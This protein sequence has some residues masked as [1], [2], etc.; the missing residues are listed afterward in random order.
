MNNEQLT[1]GNDLS[2][3]IAKLKSELNLWERSRKL[4]KIMSD[5][6]G[7]NTYMEIDVS[8]INFE[9]LKTLTIDAI[10]KD[11]DLLEQQFN[12]L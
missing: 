9:V 10:K 11:L 7:Y 12:K 5:V 1:A 8:R 3:K 4:N 6:E 2:Q